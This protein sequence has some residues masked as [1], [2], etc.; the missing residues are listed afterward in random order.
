M[1]SLNPTFNSFLLHFFLITFLFQD[2]PLLNSM[3]A[4]ARLVCNKTLLNYVKHIT[5][6]TQERMGEEEK[7]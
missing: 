2:V 6:C 4:Y 1:R 7:S 3:Q 5:E